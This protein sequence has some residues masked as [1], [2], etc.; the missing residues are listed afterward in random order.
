MIA[1]LV[2]TWGG[3]G[4][5]TRQSSIYLLARKHE[6]THPVIMCV[7]GDCNPTTF[8]RAGLRSKASRAMFKVGHID[9]KVDGIAPKLQV[10]FATVFTHQHV[11]LL[12]LSLINF[13]TLPFGSSP[14]FL[15]DTID[16]IDW[17]NL[18]RYGHDVETLSQ[19]GEISSR[20]ISGKRGLQRRDSVG[21]VRKRRK[22]V[23]RDV[24]FPNTKPAFTFFPALR[25]SHDACRA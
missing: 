7:H 3:I 18:E 20:I 25:L 23:T 4:I 8:S 14:Y 24:A 19:L 16:E 9:R 22:R 13:V 15:P 21:N 2:S 12:P 10:R 11:F 6:S 1:Y 5:L 17:R